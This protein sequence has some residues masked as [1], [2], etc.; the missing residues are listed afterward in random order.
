MPGET[1]AMTQKGIII[2]GSGIKVPGQ[3][4]I[5]AIA[6]LRRASEVWT[7]VPEPEHAEL[8]SKIGQSPHSLWPFYRPDRPRIENYKTIVTHL[9]GRASASSQVAYLTQGHPLVLDRVTTELIL[10]GGEVGIPVTVLPGI[11]SIDTILSDILYE[12]AKG[13][14]IFDATTFVRRDMKIDGRAGLLLLQPGVFG[15]D[16]P[17]LTSDAPAP[18]LS[19]LRD[20][21]SKTYPSDHPAVLIRTATATMTEREFRTSVGDLGS[22]P[23]VALGASTLWVPPLDAGS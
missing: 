15:V 7:N 14:Q 1:D 22:V 13:L 17:R 9:L 21:L 6:A 5:E 19:A 2:V 11:S 4:T 16:M 8:A 3:L 10:Q 20:A 18:R 23:S 12:P